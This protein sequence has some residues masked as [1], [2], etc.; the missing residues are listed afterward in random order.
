M[1]VSPTMSSASMGTCLSIRERRLLR[2]ASTT[3]SS[4]AENEASAGITATAEDDDAS[5]D[6]FPLTVDITSDELSPRDTLAFDRVPSST[7]TCSWHDDVT[8]EKLSRTRT[9]L[10]LKWAHNPYN[11]TL[12]V[13]VTKEYRVIVDES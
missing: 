2:L 12:P 10:V 7:K 4:S 8:S 11:M 9:R 1:H 5:Q 6:F 13:T 3:S